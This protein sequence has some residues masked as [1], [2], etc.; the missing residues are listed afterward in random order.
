M[1]SLFSCY[2]SGGVNK[3]HSKIKFDVM[4]VVSI[5]GFSLHTPQ[6]MLWSINHEGVRPQKMGASFLKSVLHDE[7]KSFKCPQLGFV[8]FFSL[9]FFNF[10]LSL[11]I[12]TY[13]KGKVGKIS[14]HGK[15]TLK[16]IWLQLCVVYISF[17]LFL[18]HKPFLLKLKLAVLYRNEYLGFFSFL[19][20][21]FK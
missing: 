8:S 5:C 6:G 15:T 4:Y 13:L 3:T 16:L 21:T 2:G 1:S 11:S 17:W 10:F 19:K 12:I 7:K 20:R 9:F 18:E 14:K